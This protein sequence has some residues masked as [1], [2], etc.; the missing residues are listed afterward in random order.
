MLKAPR[1]VPRRDR[2]IRSIDADCPTC[3][4]KA[5]THCT[6]LDGSPA[7][8]AMTHPAR[9]RMAVRADNLSRGI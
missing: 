9:R 1:F 7:A 4:V 6:R 3:R 2:Y 8:A 5:G